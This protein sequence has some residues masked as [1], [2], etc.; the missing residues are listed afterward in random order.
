VEP[1]I[2]TPASPELAGLSE[3]NLPAERMPDLHWARL[4]WAA[5][6]LLAMVAT[7]VVWS[8]VG[9]QIHLDMMPWYLKLGPLLAFSWS[10]VRFTM[11]LVEQASP[12]GLRSMR[13]LLAMLLTGGLMFAITCYYHL[14]E[15]DSSDEDEGLS[16]SMRTPASAEHWSYRA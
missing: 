1:G 6:F 9:G 15:P 11:A 5:E 7:V 3:P 13:W 4:A 16:T 12:W 14:H 8:E 2:E 10:T